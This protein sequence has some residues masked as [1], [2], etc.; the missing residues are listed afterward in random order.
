MAIIRRLKKRA[1][2]GDVEVLRKKLQS[3][4]DEQRVIEKHYLGIAAEETDLANVSSRDAVRAGYRGSRIS[5][6]RY[7]N[8]ATEARGR[9]D[10][11]RK[12]ASEA[13][14]REAVIQSSLDKLA[15]ANKPGASKFSDKL[16]DAKKRIPVIQKA[17]AARQKD[18]ESAR[19][20][21]DTKRLGVA[22]VR[23][24]R[25]KKALKELEIT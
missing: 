13:K 3:E 4:L 5:R 19:R 1:K 14:D 11:A 10:I 21:H 24:S 25:L 20:S 18:V 17:I 15:T 2:S 6:D 7:N 8:A 23:L 12:K 22:Q 9:A 16:A